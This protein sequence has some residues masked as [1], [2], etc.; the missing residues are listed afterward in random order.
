MTKIIKAYTFSSLVLLGSLYNIEALAGSCDENSLNVL[1]HV[2]RVVARK[3]YVCNSQVYG[4]HLAQGKHYIIRTTLYSGN[5]YALIGAGN[6]NVRDIDILLLDENF[7]VIDRDNS[8]DALPITEV[9][10]KWSGTYYIGVSMHA[11][12]GCSNVMICRR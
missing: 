7:N 4:R 6:E 12:R 10:P 5:H 2:E 3:G 9:T 11:G 1:R 8:H